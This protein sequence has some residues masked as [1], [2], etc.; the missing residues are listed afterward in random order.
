MSTITAGTVH[1]RVPIRRSDRYEGANH[2]GSTLGPGE[3]R[4]P[5]DK[6]IDWEAAAD[7]RYE[8]VV[9]DESKQARRVLD[10]LGLGWSDELTHFREHMRDKAIRSPTYAAVQENTHTRAVRRWERYT[11]YLA[12]AL[13]TL[14]RV[15]ALLGYTQA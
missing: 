9:Q 6:T 1:P 7:E 10:L 14:E 15:A 11:D 4:N 12:P 5:L 3:S 13:P 8:D 2:N